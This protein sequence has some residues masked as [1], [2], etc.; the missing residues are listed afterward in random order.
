MRRKALIALLA[1]GTVGG[2]A[3]GFASMRHCRTQRRD[4]FEQ[5]VAKVCVNAARESDAAA[6]A[7]A[8]PQAVQVPAVAPIIV[9]VSPGAPAVNVTP[10][11][12][13]PA[14]PAQ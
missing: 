8:P 11:A 5:H 2:Y 14:A 6:R 7:A 9:N 4:A 3:A 1:L 10:P 13:A 12:A